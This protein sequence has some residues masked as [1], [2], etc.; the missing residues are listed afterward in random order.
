MRTLSSPSAAA[1][2][3]A[4]AVI[5]AATME[6]VAAEAGVALKTVYIAFTTKSGLLRA[7]WDLRLK[8]D[9]DQATVAE[10]P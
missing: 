3:A 1:R 5:S 7:L 9:Q 8:G 6:Q 2:V 4:I 10:R